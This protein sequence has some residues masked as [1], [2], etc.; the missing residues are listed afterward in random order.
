MVATSRTRGFAIP[1]LLFFIG[2]YFLVK[3]DKNVDDNA[4]IAKGEIV[5]ISKDS[6]EMQIQGEKKHL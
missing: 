3:S 1:F 2:L 6:A 4:F 5:Y